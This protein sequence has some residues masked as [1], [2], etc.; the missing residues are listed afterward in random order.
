MSKLSPLW[1]GQMTMPVLRV[2]LALAEGAVVV[3]AAVLDRVVLALEVVDAECDRARRGRLHLARRQ[4]LDRADLQ[5]GTVLEFQLVELGQARGQRRALR[6]CA[7]RPSASSGRGARTSAAPASAG[8]RSPRAAP[9]CGIA[10]TS[11][12][13]RPLTISVS[14]DVAAWLIA[15]PRPENMILVDRVSV[16]GEGDVD[17]DLV[18]AQRVLPLRLGVCVLHNPMPARVLVV[19]EDHLAVELVEL[20]HVIRAPARE[21]ATSW[22]ISSGTV[23]R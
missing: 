21:A 16:L 23:Q 11:L 4:L 5:P 10:A 15:Q 18:A 1:R 8:C 12:A 14:I 3:G 6:P 13:F 22:S 9:P 19:V 7:A 2:E 17:R 20:A